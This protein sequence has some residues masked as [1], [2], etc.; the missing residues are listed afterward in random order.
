MKDLKSF[1]K[2]FYFSLELA[3]VKYFIINWNVVYTLAPL[4]IP[5]FPHVPF[6]GWGKE[7]FTLF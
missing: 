3:M 7:L 6:F 1:G 4:A 2:V 5:R